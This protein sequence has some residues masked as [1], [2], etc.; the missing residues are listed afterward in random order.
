M[1]LELSFPPLPHQPHQPHLGTCWAR[2]PSRPQNQKHWVGA[3]QPVFTS[4]LGDSDLRAL[5]KEGL[6]VEPNRRCLI[7]CVQVIL[8]LAEPMPVHGSAETMRTLFKTHFEKVLG[9]RSNEKVIYF[10]YVTTV[11][12]T[13]SIICSCKKS[14]LCRGHYLQKDH[15][16][17]R[18]PKSGKANRANSALKAS[19][20]PFRA[21]IL[22][23]HSLIMTARYGK[24]VS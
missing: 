20:Y 7:Q 18:K 24:H 21:H 12:V 17:L 3:Q 1:V 22:S 14:P 5:L 9:D 19:I 10:S 2:K 16:I 23:E 6:S 8:I 4:P 13:R 11:T 15:F